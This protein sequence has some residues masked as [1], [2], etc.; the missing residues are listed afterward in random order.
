MPIE[1][2]LIVSWH[3][4]FR[5]SG[6]IDEGILHP[7][8]NGEPWREVLCLPM[9]RRLVVR[10]KN[11]HCG[12][13]LYRMVAGALHQGDINF[14]GLHPSGCEKNRCRFVLDELHECNCRIFVRANWVY[15]FRG[16]HRCGILDLAGARGLPFPFA[17]FS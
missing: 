6:R 11:L 3:D 2:A 15:T 5:R 4:G 9:S 10:A 16:A 17:P 7:K 12:T 13:S 8:P 1:L 14:W